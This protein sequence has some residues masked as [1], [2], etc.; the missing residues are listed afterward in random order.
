MIGE[1]IK[2]AER[3]RAE[4]KLPPAGFK[5]KTPKWI[6]NLENGVAH[7][8]GPY[9]RDDLRTMPSP[10]RQRSG[11]PSTRNLKPYLLLD[12]ARYVLGKPEPHKEGE[13]ELLHAG[14]IALLTQARDA[15]GVQQLATVI[16]F[17]DSEEAAGIRAQVDAKDT[18]A[19]RVMGL[20]LTEL[21]DI[22]KFWYD[23]LAKE[24]VTDEVGECGACGRS[25]PI[26]RTLPRELVVLGQK[27]QL[28][29]FN[30]SAFTS[31]GKD[32]TT[33]SPLCFDC[34][35]Q[36]IDALDYLTR[37]EQHHRTI[38]FDPKASSLENQLA[39]FWLN[40]E[41]SFTVGEE[42]ID[43]EA[44]LAA[45]LDN[46]Q[47]VT[48][49]ATLSQVRAFL[50]TPWQANQAALLLDA[51]Q[52]CLGVISANKGRM[53]IREWLNESLGQVK[54]NLSRYLDATNIISP[55]GEA[56][57]PFSIAAL[58]QSTKAKNPNF[59]RGLLR[60]A[61]LSH[62]P[63]VGLLPAAVNAFRN[64]NTLQ[65]PKQDPKETWRL[66]AL[67][68]LF[69]LVLYFGTK[70]VNTMNEHD[71]NNRGP[72]YL[73]GTLLAIL[74]EAQQKS[75]FIK[76]KSRLDTTIVN[77]FYG[78][79]STAPGVNFGG[80]IRL[81]ATAHLPDVGKD[82]N[83]LVE[84]AMTKLDEVGGFPDTLTLAQQ[85]EF[86]LGFYHQRAKF[87]ADRP[88]KNKQTEGDQP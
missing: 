58:L 39:I 62:L 16:D 17:L 40:R 70:E 83:I 23:H 31:Y 76:H 18:I 19:F 74:E 73:C 67:A 9:G 15:T 42:V 34:A 3:L 48:P 7:L 57:H 13:A 52:L 88:V 78:S 30:K 60:T 64:P 56:A 85:A 1:L 61:Y 49:Q 5:P 12:D 24:L 44:M 59:T 51:T 6:I 26:L 68:S 84:D 2:A 21:L 37:T 65:N 25:H 75:H 71:P 27:C 53:V 54:A 20:N 80:L 66:H 87:R 38:W 77:R 8:Q 22:Q 28:S 55:R 69:K 35:S 63:P 82:I 46:H 45:I 50:A 43:V 72:A 81:A 11:K 79:V 4:S 47:T 29:S 36:A 10:D 33:N 32:Q 14:F 86:G 41:T